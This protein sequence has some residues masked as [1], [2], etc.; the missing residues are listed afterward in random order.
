MELLVLLMFLKNI[1]LSQGKGDAADTDFIKGIWTSM[2]E[3]YG[4]SE[5]TVFLMSRFLRI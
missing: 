4:I 2:L 3:R 1:L 5:E